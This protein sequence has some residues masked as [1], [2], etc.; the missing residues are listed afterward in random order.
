MYKT[1]CV[2]NRHLCGGDFLD[3]IRAIASEKRAD[4]LILREKDMDEEQYA[5][6]A[7]K[8][9]EICDENGIIC[10]LHNFYGTALKLN[11]KGLHLPLNVLESLTYDVRELIKE[12]FKY[13][14]ASCHS[15]EEAKKA[16]DLGC[17]YI[18]AGHIFP[19]E[20]KKDVPPRGLEFLSEVCQNSPI[21]VYAIGGIN[22]ENTGLA[23]EA[24]AQGVCIMSGFMIK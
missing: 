15:V 14:G 12:R 11:A 8:V 2:T 6:L 19:T 22:G 7:A 17:T 4:M 24:G 9:M 3:K 1:I 13:L 18:V 20:C 21:P 10:I 5:A 23:L 16:V